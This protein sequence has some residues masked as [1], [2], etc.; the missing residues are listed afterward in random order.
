MNMPK[1]NIFN[2]GRENT[3][4]GIALVHDPN[5]DTKWLEVDK[6][7]AS[8]ETLIEE[9]TISTENY[10][11]SL[12]TPRSLWGQSFDGTGNVSGSLTGVE[13][14]TSS[15]YSLRDSSSNP[16]LNL[17]IGSQNWYVQSYSDG[18]YIGSTSS[19]SL[20]IDASGN[21]SVAG[22]FGVSG[23]TTL[24]STLGVTGNTTLSG[25][26]SVSKATTLSSTLGVTGATTLSS[27]LGVSGATTLSSTLSVSG[28]STLTGHVGI[29]TS[30]HSTYVLRAD[31]EVYVST[32]LYSH[33]YVMALS[34]I[35]HKDLM[36]D[37]KLTVC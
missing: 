1:V 4:D 22:T 6:N 23:A 15:S 26:L 12:K 34:D 8:G 10:A 31:G 32:G 2:L 11:T 17:K 24:S 5:D 9:A 7:I 36:V 20:K 29:G 25:T 27:T 19:K 13:N 30:P 18:I 21:V 16:Y 14:I 37:V 33:G 35:R 3:S 28:T